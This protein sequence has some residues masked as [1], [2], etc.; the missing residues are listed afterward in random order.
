MTKLSKSAC[1]CTNLRRSA[2]VITAFYDS[3]LSE[4]G[5]SVAQYYLLINLSRAGSANITHWAEMVGLDR[6][7]MVRNI[8]SLQNHELVEIAEGHGKTFTLSSKGK[9]TLEKAIPL[10]EK[11]RLKWNPSWEKRI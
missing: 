3:M 4:T 6:S 11:R 10:W 7:T 5:L 8:K 2:N 1:Y 9:M